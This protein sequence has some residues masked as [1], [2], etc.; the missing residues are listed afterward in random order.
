VVDEVLAVGDAEFQRKCLGKMSEIAR[1]GRTVLFV[2]HNMT[3]IQQLCRSGVLLRA[4]RVHTIGAISR[5]INEYLSDATNDG[6]GVFDLAN[7]PA[8]ASHC[9][10]VIRRIILS[11]GGPHPQATF[12]PQDPLIAEV[13]L[14]L[15]QRIREPRVALAIED[16][17]NRRIMTVANYFSPTSFADL[18][19]NV[20][21]RC[22]IPRLALGSGRYLISA[23]IGEKNQQLLDSVDAAGWFTIEWDNNYGTGEDFLPVYGPVLCES[24]W[25]IVA[26]CTGGDQ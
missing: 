17:L 10:P 23:S 16:Q 6:S 8:R 4:G 15:P 22:M 5:V 25:S 12:H 9:S 11:N 19:G 24:A 21:V 26:K 7:H 2:S 1:G 13:H 14:S 18:E 3:A 20:I